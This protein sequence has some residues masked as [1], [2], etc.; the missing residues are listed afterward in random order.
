MSKDFFAQNDSVHVRIH[1][2]FSLLQIV[3]S[4]TEPPDDLLAY[5]AD[6]EDKGV[7]VKLIKTGPDMKCVLKAQLIRLLAFELE[8]VNR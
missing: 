4:E 5:K 8:E 3:Y 7:L 2:Y 1:I 6:L